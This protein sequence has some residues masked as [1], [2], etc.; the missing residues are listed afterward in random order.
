MN[1]ILRMHEVKKED[2][3]L[4]NDDLEDAYTVERL[5]EFV[6]EVSQVTSS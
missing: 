4:K 1:E 6:P 3:S 5:S 2:S